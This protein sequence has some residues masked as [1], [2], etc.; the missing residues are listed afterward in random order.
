MFLRDK[1]ALPQAHLITIAADRWSDTGRI[2]SLTTKTSQQA[3]A[4]LRFANAQ[5]TAHTAQME[6]RRKAV[7]R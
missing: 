1:A 7:A 6:A 3:G 4:S 2:Q 5:V